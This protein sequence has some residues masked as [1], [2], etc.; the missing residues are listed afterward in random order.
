MA[1]LELTYAS[2]QTLVIYVDYYNQVSEERLPLAGATVGVT[3]KDP[4]GTTLTG[5]NAATDVGNGY[6]ELAVPDDLGAEP[7]DVLTVE[8][9]ATGGGKAAYAEP[10]A[11][12]VVDRT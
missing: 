2:D 11:Q 8:V 12:V 7:G 3:I 9:T 4:D 1:L 10:Y 6:Y 5:P